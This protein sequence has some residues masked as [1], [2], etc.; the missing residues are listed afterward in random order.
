MLPAIPHPYPDELLYSLLGRYAQRLRIH[1]SSSFLHHLFGTPQLHTSIHSPTHLERLAERL[2]G[3]LCLTGEQI[4]NR[5]TLFP[6]YQ[7]FLEFT[8]A[9]R[10]VTAMKSANT[11][12]PGNKLLRQRRG[13]TTLREHLMFC[14]CCTQEARKEFGECYW[15]RVHQVPGLEICP[16]HEVWLEEST[17]PAQALGGWH[18]FVPAE[19]VIDDTT[20]KPLR[21]SEP[22]HEAM[23]QLAHDAAWLLNQT[24]L[25]S[26]PVTL[27]KR[28]RYLLREQGL[29]SYRGKVAIKKLLAQF[30]RQC[31]S[32]F[33]AR[34]EGQTGR[35]TSGRG[36]LS[37]VRK[38][39]TGLPALYHLLM[40][41]C[42]G[43]T[44]KAF[45]EIPEEPAD[46]GS[47]PWPCLNTLAQHYRHLVVTNISV[48]VQKDS[49]RPVARFACECGFEYV[50]VGPDWGPL[51]Q[52][53]YTRVEQYGPFWDRKFTRLWSAP[54]LT[55]P[56]ISQVVGIAEKNLSMH[57]ARLH[58]PVWRR[59]H[60]R[61]AIPS[62]KRTWRGHVQQPTKATVLS[63]REQWTT[64][65][66]LKSLSGA[67][68]R[69]E[70]RLYHWLFRHDHDWLI[71]QPH[72]SRISHQAG[73]HTQV[74]WSERDQFLAQVI[75]RQMAPLIPALTGCHRISMNKLI[76]QSGY[77]HLI[78][79]NLHR[80]PATRATLNRIVTSH[81][82]ED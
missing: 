41:Q 21:A 18:T 55:L 7:P 68:R 37:L 69:E 77:R 54:N 9:Q 23:R 39:R 26:N 20:P 81:M 15:H 57:A 67:P 76:K 40:M 42:L 46:F 33:L 28:Y 61:A 63:A 30:Y 12:I 13:S 32:T 56:F 78:Q 79:P 75:E 4:I 62:R 70:R 38:P 25:P 50:R 52:Y 11:R 49:G 8:R 10:V 36:V 6:Y 71:A 5:L 14:P 48:H 73:S 53:S 60:G 27:W 45:F 3:S 47:G 82:P 58:L 72:R 80:L 35:L 24:S 17:A 1:S 64:L 66:L 59:E 65:C 16:I 2:N 51:A 29:C 43:K 44:A 19:N 31:P 34:I 22:G 74:D